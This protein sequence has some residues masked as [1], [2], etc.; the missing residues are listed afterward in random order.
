MSESFSLA[1]FNLSDV[2]SNLLA[3]A[4]NFDGEEASISNLIDPF[5]AALESAINGY[6]T[7]EAWIEME[8]QRTRQ[9][10]LMN[11]LGDLQQSIIGKL[12]GWQSHPSGTAMP[13]VVGKRGKQLMLTEV[14]NKHNTMN[15][16]S[17][18]KTYD[19]LAQFLERPEFEGFTAGV[20]TVISSINH[21]AF[22]K[23]FAPAGKPKR[24][25]IVLMPGRVF[26][27]IA[28]DPLQRVPF[29]DV[30]PS[31]DLTTWASWKAI[32]LMMEE[33][34]IEIERQTQYAIPNWIKEL[35]EQAIGS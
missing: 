14:K 15:S 13:D 33:F 2:V 6:P 21:S 29:Q 3:R 18:A 12:P 10:N 25:D 32:D 31:D 34:W 7:M 17:S 26:Y 5:A 9:K 22:F 1:N 19:V 35:S 11:H 28:T 4:R 8:H 16:S 27:A 23:P 30:E 20:V 24:K